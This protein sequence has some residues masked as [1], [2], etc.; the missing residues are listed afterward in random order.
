MSI[1]SILEI[2]AL[3][4]LLTIQRAHQMELLLCTMHSRRRSNSGIS[5]MKLYAGL[6]T[7]GPASQMDQ[8]RLK[9][10]PSAHCSVLFCL[11]FSAWQA[12]ID[13]FGVHSLDCV[14]WTCVTPDIMMDQLPQVSDSTPEETFSSNTY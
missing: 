12:E 7:L 10:K 4:M 11:D 14:I 9:S 2:D 6:H 8:M 1:D 3:E 5:W 13:V